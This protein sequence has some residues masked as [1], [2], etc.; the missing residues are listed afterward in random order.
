LRKRDT[1]KKLG[2]LMVGQGFYI[3]LFLC[4]ATIGISGYYLIRSITDGQDRVEPTAGSAAVVL[5]DSE[6]NGPD[7]VGSAPTL[8]KEEIVLPPTP[9]RP[10]ELP[11]KEEQ[12]AQEPSAPA[13]EEPAP[14]KK[15]A[16]R[17]FTW[18]VKGEVLR[19]FDV[20]TLALDPTLEDWRTHGGLDIAASL[21][22]EVLAMTDGTVTQ[23]YNDGLMG[24]TVVV[25]HG[26]GLT[27]AYCN[28]GGQPPVKVG[29]AVET[30]TILGA[31]GDTA[32]AESGLVSHLHLE[33]WKDGVR[34][35]PMYYLPER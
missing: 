12:P 17:V 29:Q 13:E 26:D 23:L 22:V 31:V 33:A 28:L 35:D 27:S 32:I 21:G 5:P 3:V 9:V 20:E 16:A 24:T 1:F 2:D 34:V 25:D 11:K 19:D 14:T 10:V 4:V 18:P 8:G 30:G 7:P 15:P 6:A